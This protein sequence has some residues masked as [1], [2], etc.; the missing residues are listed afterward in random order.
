MHKLLSIIITE[1]NAP[2]VETCRLFF[3]YKFIFQN[4]TKLVEENTNLLLCI[5]SAIVT[6]CKSLQRGKSN[7]IVTSCKSLQRSKSNVIVTSCKSLQRGKSNVIVTSCKSLQR[8]KSNTYA[9]H[10]H[11]LK[12]AK[13]CS[14]LH[15][16]LVPHRSSFRIFI[17]FTIELLIISNGPIVYYEFDEIFITMHI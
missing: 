15:L 13:F 6:S 7:V 14:F 4:Y 9:S 11:Y 5:D 12:L 16:A 8:G 2:L 1:N 10:H 3:Y 17:S